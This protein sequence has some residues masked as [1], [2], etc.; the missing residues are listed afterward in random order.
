MGVE[1]EFE[2]NLESGVSLNEVGAEGWSFD[3]SLS[4]SLIWVGVAFVVSS[5]SS[6]TRI[7]GS[8]W[9]ATFDSSVSAHP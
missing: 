3:L 4:L 1:L 2:M 5:N 7:S 9:H 6:L 8:R